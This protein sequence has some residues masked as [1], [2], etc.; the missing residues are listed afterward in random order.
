MEKLGRRFGRGPRGRLGRRRGRLRGDPQL[1]HPGRLGAPLMARIA[2]F[3]DIHGNAVALEAVRKAVSAAKPDAILIAG[4]LVLNGPDPAAAIDGVRE[5]EADGALV[6]Q[7][8]TDVAVADFDYAAAFPWF[9]EGVP[10]SFRAAAEWAH[11]ALGAGPG[12]LAPAPAGRAA[13]AGRRR[14][15]PRLPRLA[16]LAD[17]RA[18]TR[19]STRT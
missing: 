1:H 19:S 16:G 9:T 10:E 14:A 6:V 5:L 15:R 17:G 2:L 18:S 12:R 8:N 4:D 3:G 11:E 7:G 13:A